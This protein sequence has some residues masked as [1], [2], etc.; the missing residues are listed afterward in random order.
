MDTTAQRYDRHKQC[1]KTAFRHRHRHGDASK[2]DGELSY[3]VGHL[4]CAGSFVKVS[5]SMLHITRIMHESKA[6]QIEANRSK[7]NI[8]FWKDRLIRL[9]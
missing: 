6:K 7:S 5:S 3:T 4:S 2:D 1:G 8:C 9:D